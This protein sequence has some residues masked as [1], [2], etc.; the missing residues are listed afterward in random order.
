[1]N[2]IEKIIKLLCGI[3]GLS[4]EKIK[5]MPIEKG[6]KI[7]EDFLSNDIIIDANDLKLEYE[8]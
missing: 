3:T 5:D 7:L 2:N 1:M 8:K 6:V 4:Q